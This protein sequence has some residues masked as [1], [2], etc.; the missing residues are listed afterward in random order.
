MK[1]SE[2]GYI[3]DD[4]V[5]NYVK[6]IRSAKSKQEL[7]LILK[8]WSWIAQDALEIATQISNWNEWEHFLKEETRGNYMGDEL[9]LKY[10]AI[11]LPEK[12][13]NVSMTANHF[14]TPWGCAYIRMKQEG[15]L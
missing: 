15:V 6:T 1:E 12:M 7:L 5:E 2:V 14:K 3:T 4:V 10:G 8:S 11:L 13:L 9:C